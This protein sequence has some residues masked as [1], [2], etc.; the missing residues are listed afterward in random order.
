MA[1]AQALELMNDLKAK[2]L[3]SLIPDTLLFLEHPPVITSGRR[4]SEDDLHLTPEELNQKGITF[5]KTDR[6]GKLTYHGPGQLVIYFIINIEERGWSVEDLAFKVEEGLRLFAEECGVT[7]TRDA[8]NHGLWVGNNKIASIGFHITKGV[9]THGA[10]LNIEPDLSPF[11]MMI[12]CGIEG[13]GATSLKK[14]GG[15]ILTIENS[16][17]R[18]A[19]IYSQ[20]L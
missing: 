9:T 12:P 13:A 7:T 4:P 1:Y 8:R 14:E 3:A 15:Q 6:G 11:E 17:A 18:L 19:A 20:I 16:A 5:I 2:R 10:A